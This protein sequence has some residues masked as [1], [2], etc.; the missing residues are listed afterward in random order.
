MGPIVIDSDMRLCCLLRNPILKLKGISSSSS[1]SQIIGGTSR[2]ILAFTLSLED[3]EDEE[4]EGD[5]K[6]DED[7]VVR[8]GVLA[9][10]ME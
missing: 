1:S 2:F 3:E 5:E 10:W 4:D 6:D 9:F 7:R 8:G